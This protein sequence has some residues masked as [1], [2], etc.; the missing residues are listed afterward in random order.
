MNSQYNPQ[1]IEQ[2][3]QQ[4]WDEKQS[5]KAKEDFSKEKFYCLAMFPYPSGNLHVGHVRNYTLPDVVARYQRMLGKN[6]MQPLGWDAFGLPA[7]NAALKHKVAPA[8]WTYK[9]IDHMRAQLQSLGFAIDWSREITTC[10]PE[11]YRWEQWLFTKMFEK[12]LAYKKLSAVNWD[13]VDQTVLANEQV[14]DGRG[15]RSGALVERKE[16]SQWFLKITDY[17][18]EL[19]SGLDQLDGWPE[20]VKLMQKNWIGKSVGADIIFAVEGQNPLTVYTT[21]PDTLYGVSYL[22]IS[23]EHELATLAAKDDNAIAQYIEQCKTQKVAEADRSTQEKTGIAT[24]FHAKHP[25]TNQLV[26]IWISNYVLQGYGSGAVMAVP[27]HDQRD[28]EFA[29]KYNLPI[30]A[31]IADQNG[32]TPDLSKQAYTEKGKLINSGEFSDLDYQAAFDKIIEKLGTSKTTNYRLHDWGLSRQRYWGAPIPIIYCDDCG[33]VAVPEEDLPVRLPENVQFKDEVL[34]LKD[35]PDFY[36]TLCPKCGKP[37]KRETDTFD[38]FMESSWYY[39]RYACPRLDKAMLNDRAKYW[40]PVDQYI[41]GVEHAV[42]HLL[43]A[44]FMHKVLRDEGLVNSDEPFLNLLTQGM[45]LKDGA[46]MSKSKGNTVDPQT[47]IDKYGADSVRVFIIFTA[48]PEQS[49]E[50]S[51]D[52]FEGCFR[53]LKRLWQLA[54]DNKTIIEDEASNKN[55]PNWDDATEA[56]KQ[57]WFDIHSSLKKITTDYQRLQLNT[58]VSGAMKIL[59]SLGKVKLNTE[60]KNQKQSTD[61][62]ILCEGFKI[63]LSILSP[64]APHITHALWKELGF[65][66]AVIHASWPEVSSIA[67]ETK[68]VTMVVQING[69][70][71]AKI[72]VDAEADK[73]STETIALN[74]SSVSK[75][76]EGKT[77]R[78]VIVVPKKLINIVV[79]E[80]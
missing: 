58:V 6:V 51:D 13:P 16:I 63:L 80:S 64:I 48:P 29:S 11:Y 57:I 2:A 60:D 26:P 38:T 7:E 28:Y 34:S 62:H 44:R 47:L 3:A 35:M 66:G 49:L 23:A 37:A 24:K 31:V 42:M 10:H 25:L 56:Q 78:K 43:Y 68:T 18:E 20:Q 54:F 41:G 32:Q 8:K 79:T 50:W 46:K 59:N 27:A 75:Y 17:A 4:Y 40:T 22:A 76:I 61:H 9:N 14:I 19:L 53:F 65:E 12:G 72:S 5:F 36:K 15:W 45:V 21:R 77:V 67:L 69:K 30:N 33:E 70:L 73:D 1:E 74:D 39:A 71:R 55:K 52:A